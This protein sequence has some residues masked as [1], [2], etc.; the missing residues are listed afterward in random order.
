MG[1]PKKLIPPCTRTIKKAVAFARKGT[2]RLPVEVERGQY[3]LQG[4]SA[5]SVTEPSGPQ[6]VTF[7]TLGYPL[8]W[9]HPGVALIST[10]PGLG[11]AAKAELPSFEI[12]SIGDP[13]DVTEEYPA[14]RKLQSGR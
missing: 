3:S 2:V 12:F 14:S 5:E 6:S 8:V 10:L 9:N 11:G 7:V 13:L 1:F 4:S